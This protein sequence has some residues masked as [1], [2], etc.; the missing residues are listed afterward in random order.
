[1]RKTYIIPDTELIRLMHERLMVTATTGDDDDNE[2]DAAAKRGFD[3][4]EEIEY[5]MWK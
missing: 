3:D 4:M 2:D 5:D 1:M